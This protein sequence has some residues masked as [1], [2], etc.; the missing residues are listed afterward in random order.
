M[1]N[2]RRDK[3]ETKVILHQTNSQSILKNSNIV[4]ELQF[5]VLLLLLL[6]MNFL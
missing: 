3:A 1:F 2:Y 5:Q 6:L 4:S